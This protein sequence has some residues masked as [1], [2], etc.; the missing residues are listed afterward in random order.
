MSDTRLSGVRDES[1]KLILSQLFS[2][3]GLNYVGAGNEEVRGILY[4]ENKISHG[5]A[6][7]GTTCERL[8]CKTGSVH[9]GARAHNERDLRDDTGADDIS[10]EDLTIPSQRVD[11]LLDTS[12]SA[13]VD[14]N[15]RNTRIQCFVHRLNE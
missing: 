13:V 5:R 6:I 1:S 3:L 12:T 7:Y 9:T 14:A 4:H 10:L 15:D 8:R 2:G 11:T